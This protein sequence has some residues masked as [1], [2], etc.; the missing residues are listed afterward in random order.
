MP[1]GCRWL[2]V[3]EYFSDPCLSLAQ[4]WTTYVARDGRGIFHVKCVGDETDVAKI[5]PAAALVAFFADQGPQE[6]EDLQ[7]AVDDAQGFQDVVAMASFRRRDI[8]SIRSTELSHR[9][10]R[11]EGRACRPPDAYGERPTLRLVSPSTCT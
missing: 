7:S 6:L 1:R 11:G 2:H 4:R 5:G 8:N 10:D 3:G 9:C